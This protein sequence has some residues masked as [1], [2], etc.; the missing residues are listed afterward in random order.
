MK[1]ILSL[2]ILISCISLV[3]CHSR[4]TKQFEKLLAIVGEVSDDQREFMEKAGIGDGDQGVFTVENYHPK[5]GS[6]RI[7]LKHNSSDADHHYWGLDLSG[8]DDVLKDIDGLK[9]EEVEAKLI[10]FVQ[11]ATVDELDWY[12]LDDNLHFR[13]S[14]SGELFAVSNSS[15]K[16]LESMGAKWETMIS[17][18]IGEKLVADYGLSEERAQ[19]V[20][21]T[22]NAYQRLSSKRSLTKSEQNAYTQELLGV[23]YKKAE[24]AFKGGGDFDQLMDRAA[25]KNG[26]SPEQVSAIIREMIL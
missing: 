3:G 8:F 12:G 1:A 14:D 16:D 26:T 21:R 6:N 10:E 18:E 5:G 22:I 9:H 19:K 20:A 24:D 17:E 11:D 15:T 4:T 25:E 23:D 13:E 2:F 7:V